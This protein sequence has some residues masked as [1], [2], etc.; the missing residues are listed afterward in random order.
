MSIA[1]T[2]ALSPDEDAQYQ[3]LAMKLQRDINCLSDAERSTKRRAC[4]KLLRVLQSEAHQLSVNVLRQLCSVNMKAVLLKC[5]SSDAVEK[6]REKSVSILLFFA[7]RK[8]LEHSAAVLQEL[9]A[10]VSERL[11]KVPYPEPTEEIRLQL[12]QLLHTYLK[13]LAELPERLSLRDVIADVANV[14]GKTAVDPF[15]DVKKLTADCV[16]VLSRAWKQDI[17]LQLGMIAKPMVTNL[18]HQHSRVR[19][20]ALHALEAL[21]PCG[22]E[23]LGELMKEV[24]LPSIQKVVFD[25][26]ASVR[27][28]LV[29]TVATWL[30]EIESSRHY[31]SELLPVLLA[32]AVD[33][34]PEVVQ[35]FNISLNDLAAKWNASTEG[36][37]DVDSMEVDESVK[38]PVYF[39]SRPPN[40]ARRLAKQVAKEVLPHLLEKTGD[41]TVQVRERYTK[42]LSAFLVLIEDRMNAHLDRIFMALA[43][44]CRDDEDVVVQSVKQCSA[45]VG[46]YADASAILAAL[47]P[48]V[49]GRLT[50]QD[51]APHRTNGLILLGMSIE[52]MTPQT[53]EPQLETITDALCET[54]VR[55]SEAADLQ[56]QLAIVI[57]SLIKTSATLLPS[58]EEIAFRLFWIVNHLVA[59]AADDSI[60]FETANAA[61]NSLASACNDT[62]EG[63]YK[64]FL[65]RLL[66][67]MNLPADKS[68]SW[69]KSNPNR[70]LFDS[71]CRRGGAACAESM[72][73]LVPVFILHLEPAQ[74]AD[75]RLAF[76]ALLETMLGTES[77]CKAFQPY[78][79]QLL[80]KAIIP[81]VVWQGGRVAATIR[82]VAVACT[83]TL[84]RQGLADQ[85]CLF[86]TAPQMLPVLKSSMD[87]GDAKTRQLVC[88]ALQ[89][90]FVALPG[91]LG[92]EPVHQLYSEILKRLDDSN[93]TVRRAACQ[94]FKMFLRAAPKNHFKG[95]II[96][97]TLDCLF[98]HLDDADSDIQ[99]T[100]LEVIKE[101]VE[102]DTLL[103]IKKAQENRS[104][105]QTPKYCDQVLAFA[106]AHSS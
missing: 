106:T 53:I 76:L 94:T 57:A 86:D 69:K 87:D 77:I 105:H 78:S 39:S 43:K 90:L 31:E 55:E 59:A 67:N 45:V 6:C 81:N 41:W 26:A 33:D 49:A 16:I 99:E 100:V 58:K 92:E 23:A 7:E 1:T 27:K 50:G 71:V 97:Y 42:I 17:A 61:L 18:G 70:V 19:V 80:L 37:D 75:L 82:K 15:P 79:T 44:I 101:T 102:I 20:S 21:V 103:L 30:R 98:V 72:E 2:M 93:D 47:L 85:A 88:L 74:D 14:L 40:G 46:H 52:G 84:L 22:S 11:G 35:T 3:Q 65:G 60:A 38:P 29:L 9:V 96:D 24:L 34:S 54:G 66:Q 62:A 10:L 48:I 104:R 36:S 51:T 13:Q 56:D 28:Q 4:D 8:A 83:Y 63:L 89:Y 91:C 68:A 64:C 12:L 32:G 73:S 25:H 95:T 5:A